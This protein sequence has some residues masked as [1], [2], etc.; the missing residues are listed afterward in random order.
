MKRSQAVV[1]LLASLAAACASTPGVDRSE[2]R[3]VLGREADVR[4]DA[5]I[6]ADRVGAGSSIR[7][8]WEV[9][10]Q[11]EAPIAIADLV[12]AVSYDETEHTIVIHL[13]SEVPGNELVPRLIR[14]GSGETKI[15]HGVAKVTLHLPPP[16]PLRSNPRLLQVRLSF[17]SE[18]GPFEELVGITENAIRDPE[19]ANRM[20]TRWVEANE[21]IRTNTLPIDWTGTGRTIAPGPPRRRF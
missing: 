6:F 17:L 3:R 2:P 5:Q 10:N 12:P 4:L 19:M 18:V 9:E 7:M 15:F 8:T 20:F 16:S 21:T 13:G 11:R 1:I 14:V